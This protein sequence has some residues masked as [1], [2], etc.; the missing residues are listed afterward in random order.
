MSDDRYSQLKIKNWMATKN[1]KDKEVKDC[2][3][4]MIIN[5]TIDLMIVDLLSNNDYK[6]KHLNHRSVLFIKS[7]H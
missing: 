3:V 2:C 7:I 4:P 1:W 5:L 6:L